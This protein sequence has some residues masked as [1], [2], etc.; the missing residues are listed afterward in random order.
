VLLNQDKCLIKVKELEFLGHHLSA[1]GIFPSIDKIVA[2]QTFRQP[3]TVEELRSFL[4]L[5]T[6]VGRFIPNLANIT[7]PLR[8]LLKN[9]SKFEWNTEQVQAFC[10]LKEKISNVKTLG[11]YNPK[12]RTR[13]IADASPVAIGAVLVQFNGDNPRV[14]SYASKS[15][16]DTEKRYCQTEKEALAL[17]WAVEKF[18]I[19]LCGL[20]FELETDHRPF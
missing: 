17:V 16:T 10:Q 2:I 15:L 6:F 11:Y 19:Y 8:L 3:S 5:V 4:G 13:V 7:D 18:Y 9:S 12:D 14:I 20:E 1:E